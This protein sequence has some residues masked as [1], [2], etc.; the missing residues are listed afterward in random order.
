MI[1]E[2]GSKKNKKRVSKTARY[3]SPSSYRS[4]SY[5]KSYNGL[6]PALFFNVAL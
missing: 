6:I 1:K 5:N 4:E 3:P 2:P